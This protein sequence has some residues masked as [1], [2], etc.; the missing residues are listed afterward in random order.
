LRNYHGLSKISNEFILWNLKALKIEIE[1][2]VMRFSVSD[3]LEREAT[4]EQRLAGLDLADYLIQQDWRKFRNQNP[5][6]NETRQIGQLRK[7][8][9][10]AESASFENLRKIRL[11]RNQIRNHQ[12]PKPEERANTQLLAEYRKFQGYS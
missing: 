12:I 3:F 6:E 1:L 9:G 10:E 7:A 11:V 5:E 8:I 2:K 4:E